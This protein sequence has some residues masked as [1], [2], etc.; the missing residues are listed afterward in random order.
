[1]MA[2]GPQSET[3]QEPFNTQ[4]QSIFFKLPFNIRKNVYS[5]VFR[6]ERVQLQISGDW[7][8]A[9]VVDTAG[10]GAPLKLCRQTQQESIEY[11]HS[12]VRLGLAS[13]WEGVSWATEIYAHISNIE[14]LV[15]PQAYIV[16]Y[17]S[18][19]PQ[20]LEEG[21]QRIRDIKEIQDRFPRAHTITIECGTQSI[22]TE[23]LDRP[24]SKIKDQEQKW[25][26]NELVRYQLQNVPTAVLLPFLKPL[27]NNRFINR[28]IELGGCIAARNVYR[29]QVLLEID[30]YGLDGRHGLCGLEVKY[31]I[32][33]G[34]HGR[35][36]VSAASIQASMKLTESSMPYLTQR[37]R[38][39]AAGSR[40]KSS[41]SIKLRF[42]VEHERCSDGRLLFLLW[43][44]I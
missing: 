11:F 9:K 10:V 16:P 15:L 22:D 30:L 40:A 14:H 6:G 1:M 25:F 5:W 21:R 34:S 42:L 18:Q 38:L 23:E 12:F 43:T 39:S 31:G 32:K 24:R 2:P 3:G 28:F 33:Y 19:M 7:R 27:W 41:C 36:G 20:L 4:T 35:I 29:K 13:N 37:T 8:S 44:P 26:K 17:H